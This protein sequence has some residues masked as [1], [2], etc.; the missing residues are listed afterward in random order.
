MSLV[1]IKHRTN[2]SMKVNS[3]IS[4]ITSNPIVKSPTTLTITTATTEE[5][6]VSNTIPITK[7]KTGVN[8]ITT[9]IS[10]I[11]TGLDQEINEEM[12]TDGRRKITTI[13]REMVAT[14]TTRTI[15]RTNN[16][17][18]EIEM[19]VVVITHIDREITN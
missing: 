10:R 9:R 11:S 3:K 1:R 6:R 8:R 17:V 14:L 12:E 4:G 7:T 19:E 16:T 18:V 2:P 13:I 5:A 15:D